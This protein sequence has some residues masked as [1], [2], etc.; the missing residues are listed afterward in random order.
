MSR[1]HLSANELESVTSALAPDLG[2]LAAVLRAV[3]DLR[4]P[5]ERELHKIVRRHPRPSGR[6]FSKQELILGLGRFGPELGLDSSDVI[7][8]LRGK[9]IRTRSGV[10][11]VTLLTPPHPCP[12]RCLFCPNDLRMPKSYL[13]MEPGAQ[14]A[15]Q[16]AF[17]PFAQTLSRIKALE[18]NGHPTDKIELIVLGGTW[19]S[20][21]IPFQIGF[22]TRCFEALNAVD[23]S[24]PARGFD[25]SDELAPD[26]H[27]VGRDIGPGH[28][29][30]T[31]ISRLSA[32]T[33]EATWS[34][35]A[36]AHRA[37][38][39]AT[40][41]SVGLSLE[42]RPDSLSEASVTHLRRLGATKIQLGVE[43]TSDEILERNARGHDVADTRSAF[44]LLRRAGFK[45]Q[46]HWMPNLLGATPESDL[47]DF[48]RLFAD[49][50]LRP[51][52]LKIYPTVL[53]ESAELARFAESGEW[54]PYSDEVLVELLAEILSR[55]PRYC[56]V[57]RVIRD[58]PAHDVVLGTKTAN[59][60]ELVE[61]RLRLSGVR[62][63]E[64]RSR[65]IGSASAQELSLRATEYR[66]SVGA[67]LFLEFVTPSDDLAGF[68]RLFLPRADS[69]ISELGGAAIIREV[70]VY[71]PVVSLGAK[72]P[73]KTQHAGVG[74][75]LVAEARNRAEAAGFWKLSVISAVGTRPYYRGLG[76]EDGELYQH[77][78]SGA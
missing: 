62:S 45:I 60:R 14:R 15:A 13:S 7:D 73:R 68:L 24:V 4:Q 51:D 26:L 67:E 33:L 75:A 32:P 59:L 63:L 2:P 28:S 44:S 41:R 54:V 48:Q 29:Y 57:S 9:P 53:I 58:I 72:D 3:A 66:T 11:P 5:D 65:E 31:V 34:E 74:R 19:S 35:L 43:S 50:G 25:P 1:R 38:E 52:E 55:V 49:E 39:T 42:T 47:E 6:V 20:Y 76:F 46:A 23:G 12:G 10:A 22:V 77:V 30:N 37:N 17:D 71:G 27:I 8:K 70:H 18:T 78:R 61:A 56:R 21:P 36:E 69:F 40:H 16:H 64:I